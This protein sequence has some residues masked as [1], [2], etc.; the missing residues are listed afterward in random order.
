MDDSNGA[1]QALRI[2]GQTLD[3]VFTYTVT[4]AGGLTSTTQI[5][6]TV[7]GRNDA[8]VGVNDTAIAVEAGGVNNSGIG[9]Q[10]VGNVLAN[11]TDVDSTTNGETKTV[12]GVAAGAQS[13]ATGMLVDCDGGLW[14][15]HLLA[16][17]S[18]EYTVDNSNA[19]VQ[20]LRLSSQTLAD[21]FTYEVV[22]AGGLTSLATITVTIQ[23][24]NDT[25]YDLAATGMTIAESSANGT[26]V[27]TIVRSELDANDT[28]QYSLV[29]DAGGRF[30]IDAGTGVVTVADSSLLNYE[31]ATSHTITVR[32]IDLAGAYYDEAF[33]VSLTDIDEFDVT[34][35]SDV[36]AVINSVAENAATGTVVGVTAFAIDADGTNNEVSYSLDDDASGRFAIDSTTGVVT[37]ADGSGLNYESVTSHAITVRAISADGSTSTRGFTIALTDM[38]EFDVTAI[39]DID[40]GVNFVEEDATAG[41]LVGITAFAEDLDGTATVTYSLDDDAGGR[42]TIDA[43]SGVVSLVSVD[44]ESDPTFQIVVRATSSDASTSTRS[45]TIAVGDYNE[46][47]VSS[48]VDT[49][50]APNVVEENSAIGTSVGVSLY[51]YDGDATF[52]SVTYSLE[53]SAGGR[54]TIDADTGLITVAGAIDFEQTPSLTIRA[55]ATSA[56]GS[57][58]FTDVVITVNNVNEKPIATGIAYSTSFIDKLVVGGNGV[59]VMA[60]DPESDA[61]TV[62]LVSGT[63]HGVVSLATD[64]TFVYD[65]ETN[66]IGDVT[67]VY[68]ISDGVLISDDITVTIH[69]VLP[70]AVPAPSGGDSGSGSGGSGQATGDALAGVDASVVTAQPTTKASVEVTESGEST[71]A[72]GNEMAVQVEG[73]LSE[74]ASNQTAI[75]VATL[76]LG[77]DG[78]AVGLAKIFE[79]GM[80]FQF[81]DLTKSE[82]RSRDSREDGR[83]TSA[84]ESLEKRVEVSDDTRAHIL[85]DTVVQTVIGTGLVVWLVQGAQLL[86]TLLSA[87]PAWIQLDPLNVLG[88]AKLGKDKDSQAPEE[89]RIFEK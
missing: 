62:Q 18:Y 54:F 16:D 35:P 42:F 51:A 9:F 24:A 64:G 52:N 5:T 48:I 46:F 82:S 15:D 14:G 27:G 22:D 53:D 70:N 2:N 60:S 39:S 37:V 13:S 50:N 6:I 4:D 45:F 25:P 29:D 34:T 30:A 76:D 69:V 55:K 79:P 61:M 40:S 31:A 41:T 80:S 12:S 75:E 57:E 66:F 77:S 7:R 81:G 43:V 56:D 78:N 65:P 59:L 47:A 63:A 21:V 1:V 88:Q 19:A 68:R 23:G 85:E 26:V 38:D 58:S 44:R 73:P 84:L 74:T 10:P 11:D 49:N 20:A 32:V 72:G 33:T 3:D 28:P 86:A 17:G 8:P 83:L 67:F 89:E 87:T 71:I 36:N